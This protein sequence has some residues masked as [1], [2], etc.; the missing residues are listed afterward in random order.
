[1]ESVFIYSS[2]NICHFYQDVNLD[3][4]CYQCLYIGSTLCT[5]LLLQFYYALFEYLH[6]FISW[7]E[8]MDVLTIKF[9]DIFSLFFV[10]SYFN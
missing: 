7:P 1:M 6:V 9:S 10:P 3:I 8:D 5:K 4:Q 2:I